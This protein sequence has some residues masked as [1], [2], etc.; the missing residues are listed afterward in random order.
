MKK[1]LTMILAFA[2]VFALGVGGTL[3]W[4]TATDDPITNTFTTS[5]ITVELAETKSNFQMVPGHTIDKDPKVTVGGDVDAYVFVKVEESENY[6]EYM[7]YAIAEGWTLVPGQTNVYYLTVAKDATIKTFSVLAND[8]VTVL[9]SVTKA[10]ME[11]AK[12]SAPTLTFTAYASQMKQNADT[13]FSPEQAWA[14]VANPEQA[15]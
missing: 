4:L 9:G 5:D 10:D 2:L 1:T 14:N 7:T 6:D 11:D 12:T 8:Q 13:T 15:Y 3:A